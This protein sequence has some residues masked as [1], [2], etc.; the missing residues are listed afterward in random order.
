[1][2]RFLALHPEFTEEFKFLQKIKKKTIFKYIPSLESYL[3]NG[4]RLDVLKKLFSKDF[5]NSD[6]LR[7]AYKVILN[8]ES[9]GVEKMIFKILCGEKVY[10]SD[11]RIKFV[12][13]KEFLEKKEL[14][15]SSNIVHETYKKSGDAFATDKAKKAAFDIQDLVFRKV[16]LNEDPRIQ[17]QDALSSLQITQKIFYFIVL[18]EFLDKKFIKNLLYSFKDLNTAGTKN[19]EYWILGL[20][21]LGEEE[22]YTALSSEL[23]NSNFIDKVRIYRTIQDMVDFEALCRYLLKETVRNTL[24]LEKMYLSLLKLIELFELDYTN[25]LKILYALMRYFLY[26]KR[27]DLFLN[28]LKNLKKA[29]KHD[30]EFRFYEAMDAYFSNTLS[31]ANVKNIATSINDSGHG[32]SYGLDEILKRYEE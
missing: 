26:E 22:F 8:E 25:K 2:D 13:Y 16:Y 31:L 5:Y 14:F 19:I 15:L 21:S 10:F 24:V 30:D 7:K 32:L 12:F 11:I 28:L 27:N 29:K 23:L 17:L 4:L 6:R 18:N 3:E 1:M 9:S 20:S